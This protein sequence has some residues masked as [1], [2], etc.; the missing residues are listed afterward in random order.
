[1]PD[2]DRRAGVRNELLAALPCDVLAQILPK[3]RP[4]TLEPRE[5]LITPEKPI[6]AVYFIESGFVSLVT[7]LED[8]TQAEVGLVGREGMVGLPLIVGVDSAFEEAFVQA[9]GYCF[10]TPG[11]RVQANT[12]R[13]SGL[14][15]PAASI[16]RS[17]A[18]TDHADRRLQRPPRS[19]ATPRSLAS[20]GSRSPGT[21]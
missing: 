1:M 5:I 9:D 10:A 11:Q 7:T 18:C 17:D 3:L 13:N 14:P 8:G 4:I 15:D 19:A 2:A 20:D 21:R 12:K 6:E 16:Y